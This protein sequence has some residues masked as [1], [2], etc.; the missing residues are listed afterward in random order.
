MV[1]RFLASAFVSGP[2]FIILALLV[3]KHFRGVTFGDRPIKTLVNIMRITILISLLML[4]SEVF[5]E[6]YTG[7]SHTASARYLYFGLHG[8][9]G[10][11]SWIWTSVVLTIIAALLLLVPK[12]NKRPRLARGGLCVR[13]CRALDREGHGPDHPRVHPLDAVRDRRIRP[14]PELMADHGRHLGVWAYDIDG[15]PEDQHPDLH[16]QGIVEQFK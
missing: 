14:V 10:L 6:M 11:V 9:N 12:V 1:P 13:V 8:H 7:G 16:R 15:C 2:V 4:A 5:T 3:L